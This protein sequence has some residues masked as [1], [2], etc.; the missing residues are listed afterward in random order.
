MPD[1]KIS[2]LVEKVTPANTDTLV[3]VDSE[4][5]PVQTKKILRQNVIRGATELGYEVSL[6][7]NSTG[8]SLEGGELQFKPGAG[9]NISQPIRL[10][11]YN[12]DIRLFRDDSVAAD[13]EFQIFQASSGGKIRI[14]LKNGASFIFDPD[15]DLYRDVAD[16]LRIDDAFVAELICLAGAYL[17]KNALGG[18]WGDGWNRKDT[19]QFSV[20]VDIGVEAAPFRVFYAPAGAN[21]ITWT[22]LFQFDTQ[23]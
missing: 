1:Q 12:G 4:V 9:E 18:K 7:G 11:R 10:D 21:P 13:K 20:L 17:S 3:L 22:P 23:G 5:S 8:G 6:E 19:G 2:E 16:V 14:R 15:V